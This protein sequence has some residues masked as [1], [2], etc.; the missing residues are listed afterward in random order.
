MS[1][2]GVELVDLP[3]M[4]TA[5]VGEM[6]RRRFLT[7]FPTAAAG[8]TLASGPYSIA[9]NGRGTLNFTPGGSGGSLVT[10]IVYVVSSSEFLVLNTDS[11]TNN[12]AH[13]CRLRRLPD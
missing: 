4:S 1:S 5:L 8:I 11:Q 7:D 6:M 9:S 10:N 2:T 13:W 12:S 3:P